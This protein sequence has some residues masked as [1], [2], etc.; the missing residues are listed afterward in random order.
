MTHS[1]LFVL[2]ASTFCVV[3]SPCPAWLLGMGWM[4]GDYNKSCLL[5]SA[6]QW[7]CNNSLCV[8]RNV[9]LALQY[10]L[11]HFTLF[12]IIISDWVCFIHVFAWW[13]ISFIG[14]L[15]YLHADISSR[16]YDFPHAELICYAFMI[17][18]F[19]REF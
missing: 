7:Q 12:L 9:F 17:L 16:Q 13:F 4:G 11:H 8:F 10:F 15:H 1:I 6:E 19:A 18:M 3:S 2:R 5:A 14:I